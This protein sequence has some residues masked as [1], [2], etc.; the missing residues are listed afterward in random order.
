M[1]S[2]PHAVSGMEMLAIMEQNFV[3][4]IALSPAPRTEGTVF[5]NDF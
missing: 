5:F 2:V 3:L 4:L 1:G